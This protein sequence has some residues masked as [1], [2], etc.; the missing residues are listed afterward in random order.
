M[1][2]AKRRRETL[3]GGEPS[4]NPIVLML[5][6]FDAQQALL[7][8]DDNARLA[9]VRECMTRAY[10]R[11]NPALF[12]VRI[13]IRLG[14]AARGAVLHPPAVPK[15]RSLHLCLRLDLPAVR[16][17]SGERTDGGHRRLS[18]QGQ[19]RPDHRPVR[20]GVMTRPIAVR[21]V[22]KFGGVAFLATIPRR[23]IMLHGVRLTNQRGKADGYQAVAAALDA[24]PSAWRCAIVSVTWGGT[25]CCAEL[26]PCDPKTAAGIGQALNQALGGRDII[27]NGLVLSDV[28][29]ALGMPWSNAR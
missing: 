18:A 4:D 14:R 6:V 2:E 24:L 11:P 8:M 9:V 13:R 1:G 29:G 28:D 5:D 17:A 3:D 20:D 7:A 27:L 25:T 10:R 22:R 21:V 16:S 26:G 19:A 12:G 15:G 23:R